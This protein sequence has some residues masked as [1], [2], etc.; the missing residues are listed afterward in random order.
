MKQKP[1]A[2][3]IQALKAGLVGYALSLLVVTLFASPIISVHVDVGHSHPQH[4][5]AHVHPIS[6][7]FSSTLPETFTP[8]VFIFVFVTLALSYIPITQQRYPEF[9]WQSRAPPASVR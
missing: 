5:A 2:R 3:L 4:T 9:D 6:S 1:S 7:F 8:F